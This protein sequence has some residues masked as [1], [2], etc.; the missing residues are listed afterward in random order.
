[1]KAAVLETTP[2][3]A[4]RKIEVFFLGLAL[5]GQLVGHGLH[6]QHR[7]QQRRFDGLARPLRQSV[8]ALAAHRDEDRDQRVLDIPAGSKVGG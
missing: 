7:E 1:M 3:V 8:R 5:R 6:Q 4:T 2:S